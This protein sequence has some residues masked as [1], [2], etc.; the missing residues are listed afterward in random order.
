VLVNVAAQSA[1]LLGTEVE[2]LRAWLTELISRPEVRDLLAGTISGLDVRYEYGEH[3]LTGA[4]MPDVALADGG[5]VAAR[6]RDGCGLLLAVSGGDG[7][8]RMLRR[9]GAACARPVPVAVAARVPHDVLHGAQTVL[10][11]P[12]GYVAWAGPVR[13]DPEFALHRWFL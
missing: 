3:P 12:D 13:A 11:R 7:H 6:L 2:P 4:R 9:L 1:L 8:S 5:T 10:I